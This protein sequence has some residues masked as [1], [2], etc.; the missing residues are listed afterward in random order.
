MRVTTLCGA[1]V[2]GLILA[3]PGLACAAVN[4]VQDPGFET[5]VAPLDSFLVIPGSGTIGPWNVGGASVDVNN[6]EYIASA[7]GQQSID[8][9]GSPGAGSVSQMLSTAAGQE[10]VLRFAIAGNAAEDPDFP[11]PV[12]KQM[13]VFWDGQLID[14]PTFDTTGHSL[15]SPGWIYLQYEVAATSTSSDLEFVSLTSGATGPLLDDVSV[16]VPE[17]SSLALVGVGGLLMLRRSRR[18][19]GLA[20]I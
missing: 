15:A 10:Y 20:H 11:S 3:G 6:T 13:E 17:P 9:T 5:P 7:E 19:A 16:T 4:L 12:V 1:G 18:K 2:L 14:S 8:L